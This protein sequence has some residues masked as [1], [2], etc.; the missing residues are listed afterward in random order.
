MKRILAIATALV[1]IFPYCPSSFSSSSGTNGVWVE[2][3]QMSCAGTYDSYCTFASGFDP[4]ASNSTCLSIDYKPGGQGTK[5]TPDSKYLPIEFIVDSKNICSFE[6]LWLSWSVVG[7]KPEVVFETENLNIQSPKTQNRRSTFIEKGNSYG[8]GFQWERFG[9]PEGMDY[10]LPA[11]YKLRMLIDASKP[12]KIKIDALYIGNGKWRPQDSKPEF[13]PETFYTEKVMFWTLP[14]TSTFKNTLQPPKSSIIS[15]IDINVI[16]DQ[17]EP[18]VLAITGGVNLGDVEISLNKP[19]VSGNIQANVEF[20]T[21]SYM[22]KRFNING[23][24][25][26]KVEVAEYVSKGSK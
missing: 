14:I 8:N 7:E 6:E 19:L 16:K 10:G 4:E 21:I 12:F 22:K 5:L 25:S 3:A 23:P 26:E 2:D 24:V 20:F 17:S 11:R 18:F 1:T 13:A 9:V 15:E